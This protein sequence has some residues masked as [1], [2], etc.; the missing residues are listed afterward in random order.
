MSTHDAKNALIAREEIERR[1]KFLEFTEEDTKRIRESA[2]VL[3]PVA[4]EVA[5]RFYD[6]LQ[7]FSELVP[8]LQGR[9]EP[10]KKTQA[11]YFTELLEGKVDENYV[12][13]RERVG[14]THERIGLEPKWY[15]GAFSLYQQLT[16]RAL[17]RDGKSKEEVVEGI[18]SLAKLIFFDMS[19]AIDT[20]IEALMKTVR[21]QEAALRE[22][23]APVIEVWDEILVLPI[24]G[25]VDT[26]RAQEINE[27]LLETVVEKQAR[28]TIIDIT[29]LP[30]VDTSTANHLI[31][32]V[33]SIQLLGAETIITGVRPAIAQT[34]VTLGID[35][36][37]LKTKSR[38]V[39]GLRL[40]LEL[41]GRAVVDE[42]LLRAN[43]HEGRNGS[44][45][46]NGRD[47]ARE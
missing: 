40:A 6:H 44:A 7:Q 4:A 18:L 5:D 32:T 31:K 14:Q 10:L 22:L 13:T 36:S 20:Y 39:D 46:R 26:R 12:R 16:A 29:G 38:L 11:A 9:I 27:A 3:S 34:I 37:V 25:S 23:S 2:G 45:A 33:Q 15:M 47:E 30:V 8:F 42:N 19:V 28:V 24:V 35:T 41:T 43:G 17:D 1:L 21:G